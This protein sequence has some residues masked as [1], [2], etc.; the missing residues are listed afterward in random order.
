VRSLLRRGADLTI[1]V[2]WNDAAILTAPFGSEVKVVPMG[3]RLPQQLVSAYAPDAAG[4]A[5]AARWT[6]P[7]GLP[8]WSPYPDPARSPYGSAGWPPQAAPPWSPY[9]WLS[10]QG[11]G[12]PAP[13]W[14]PYGGVDPYTSYARV[15]AGSGRTSMQGSILLR[16][17]DEFRDR[18]LRYL[19][20][21][22]PDL[23]HAHD[24][25]TFEAAREGAQAKR[26]PWVAHVHS[27]E[28]ERRPEG[29]DSVIERMEQRLLHAAD[30]IVAPSN[31]TRRHICDRYGL[32]P[33]SIRVVPNVLSP[34]HID[35]EETGRF[36][37]ARAI[38]L[39]RLAHQKGL[40]RFLE[41][42]RRVRSHI[43]NAEFHVYGAGYYPVSPGN[44]T[45]H[46]PLSWEHRN[47]AFRDASILIVPSRAEPFGMVVLEAMQHR[48]PV[49]YPRDSGVAEVLSSGLRVDMGDIGAIARETEKLLNDLFEWEKV[50]EAQAAEIT[51]YPARGFEQALMDLWYSLVPE[52]VARG[53]DVSPAP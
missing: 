3:I 44:A 33:D 8:A 38:F 20:S 14:S 18:F 21:E 32:T 30:A 47:D 48:V 37:S 51:Q 40:D 24:W 50:V 53:S 13:V 22:S 2:P 19:A 1:V 15:Q 5:G 4:L 25:V 9:A 27:I 45:F 49:I 16:L 35:P 52:P 46:G 12:S 41:V 36:E 23:I 7:Y 29:A 17:I 39:G 34:E 10:P 6:S 43:G 26:I 42:A 28:S 31:I 11:G